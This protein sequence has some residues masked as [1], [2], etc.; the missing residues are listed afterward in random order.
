MIIVL[1]LSYI[2]GTV[3]CACGGSL[4]MLRYGGGGGGGGGD[5]PQGVAVKW[6]SSIVCIVAV[7][8]HQILFLCANDLVANIS[9]HYDIMYL[10]L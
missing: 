8:V 5:M 2:S 10:H 4:T 1:L 6:L 7:R 9:V 3:L